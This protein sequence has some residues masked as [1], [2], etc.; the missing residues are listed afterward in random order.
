[1]PHAFIHNTRSITV[2]GIRSLDGSDL[3]KIECVVNLLTMATTGA[4]QR[5][6]EPIHGPSPRRN[7]LD[8]TIRLATSLVGLF[9]AYAVACTLALK[10]YE[11]LSKG[12]VNVG[13][14]PWAVIA[15]FPVAA[16]LFSTIPSLLEQ[17]RVKLYS[18]RAGPAQTGYFSLRPRDQ[19]DKFERADNA[20][21]DTLHWIETTQESVLYLTGGSGTGKSS[22]LFAWV[23]PKLRREQWTVIQLSGYDI[24]HSGR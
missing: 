24:C 20:H 13:L 16:L 2:T 5:S 6:V 12:L 1:V 14:P 17:R 18:Q 8:A 19:E 15:A 23:I 9:T 21:A 7:W 11:E 3:S 4:A 22:L 10:K